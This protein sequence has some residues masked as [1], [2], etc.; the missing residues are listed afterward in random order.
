MPNSD[1]LVL[2]DNFIARVGVF[3]PQ[4]ELWRD[5]LDKHGIEERNLVGEELLQLCECIQLSIMFSKEAN[6]LWH[7]DTPCNKAPSYE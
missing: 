1:L 2:V 7:L 6:L 4:D 5:V 3:N